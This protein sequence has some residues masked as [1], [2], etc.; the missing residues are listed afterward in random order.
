MNRRDAAILRKVQ[1][2]DG[3][4]EDKRFPRIVAQLKTLRTAEDITTVAAENALK[5]IDNLTV[6]MRKQ[7]LVAK[8]CFKEIQNYKELLQAVDD[9]IAESKQAMKEAQVRL[10]EARV[11]RKNKQEYDALGQK[12]EELPSRAE[13]NKKLDDI[14]AELE[15]LRLR[16][17][18]LQSKLEE[19]R[20]QLLNLDEMLKTMQ[21]FLEEDDEALF[22]KSGGGDEKDDH[23]ESQ[24]KN[25]KE[26]TAEPEAAPAEEIMEP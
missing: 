4:L 18:L 9:Q 16:Q 25:E 8:V 23:E 6:F 21:S 3:T 1:I 11:I 2:D 5:E 19:R 13:T 7:A 20:T 14:N 24:E 22:G 12:V 10:G 26:D 15:R 17:D